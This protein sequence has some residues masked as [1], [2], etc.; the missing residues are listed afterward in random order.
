MTTHATRILILATIAVLIGWAVASWLD[1]AL[2]Q[3][4]VVGR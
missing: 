4:V 2:G 1:H 3:I